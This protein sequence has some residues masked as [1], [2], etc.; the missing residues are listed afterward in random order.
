M[1]E[2]RWLEYVHIVCDYGNNQSVGEIRKKLQ[3]R[4]QEEHTDIDDTRYLVWSEWIDVPTV[5]DD[6]K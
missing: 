3:Y 1:F 6:L 4:Q 5:C 2:L